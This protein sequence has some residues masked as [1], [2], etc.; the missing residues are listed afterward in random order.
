MKLYCRD[1]GRGPVDLVI[2]NTRDDIAKQIEKD[3]QWL[4]PSCEKKEI[5]NG[6]YREIECHYCSKKLVRILVLKEYSEYYIIC[7]SCYTKFFNLERLR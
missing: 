2:E 4:C 6:W 5:E 3:S 1:C 7:E